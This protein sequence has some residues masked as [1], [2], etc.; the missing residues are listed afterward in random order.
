MA[1]VTSADRLSGCWQSSV[2]GERVQRAVQWLQGAQSWAATVP[3]FALGASS[4]GRFVGT[5]PKLLPIQAAV[6]ALLPS[7]PF[8][9]AFG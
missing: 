3:L 7:L 9:P 5:L 8:T 2:D 6:C 1:A 4:G